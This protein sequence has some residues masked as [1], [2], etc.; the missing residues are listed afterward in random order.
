[1]GGMNRAFDMEKQNH[2]YFTLWYGVWNRRTQM[3]SCSRGG[4]PPALLYAPGTPSEPQKLGKAGRVVGAMP[5]I[6]YTSQ[7]FPAPH[8]STLLVFS[9]GAYE[10][11]KRDGA[12]W[13]LDGFGQLAGQRILK[14]GTS[15]Q[16]MADEARALCGQAVLEDDFSLVRIFF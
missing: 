10:I 2:M 9:D 16:L 11:A 12:M 4:H 14:P 15:L 13:T 8:G 1:M 7:S 3:I 5:D 6:A